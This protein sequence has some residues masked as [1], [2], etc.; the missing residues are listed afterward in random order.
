MEKQIWHPGEL[1]ATS[2]YYW[3]TC[4][5]HAGVKLDLFTA[6]GSERRTADDIA[7]RLNTD[8]RGTAMLLDALSAMALLEKTADAFSNTRE[9]LTYLSQDSPDYIGFMILH[10]HHLVAS[11]SQLDEAVKTGQPVRSRANLQDPEIRKNF[12]MGMFN[13]AMNTAPRLVPLADLSGR[14]HLLDLGGG[15]GTYAIHFC[16]HNPDLRATVFDLPTT[17][18]FALETIERFGLGDRIGF[19]GGDYLTD[20]IPGEYDVVW[21]SHILHG[22]G[23]R[24]C[25]DIIAKAVSAL[26]PGG[27]ILV[28][29]FILDDTRDRPLFPALFSLNMLLG[30]PHGQAYAE[31]EITGMLEKAGI[32]RIRRLFAETPNDSDVL[33][34]V[35]VG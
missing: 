14:R 17:R 21:L 10:H 5:L 22:E 7:A 12:L 35:K 13:L 6:V 11:W 24:D 29:D 33:V 8:P 23:P 30:T 20:E 19:V 31:K 4:T 2:G 32:G 34:G 18:P 15:P 16:R 26:K 27:L 9:S 28:H 1:L 25:E 3:Q